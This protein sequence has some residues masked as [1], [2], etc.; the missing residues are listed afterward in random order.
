MLSRKHLE[1]DVGDPTISP[2]VGVETA[3]NGESRSALRTHGVTAMDGAQSFWT[4]NKS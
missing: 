2:A 4:W 3:R 1:I